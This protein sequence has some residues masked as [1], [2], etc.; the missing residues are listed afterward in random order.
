M[1]KISQGRIKTELAPC[2]NIFGLISN[3]ISSSSMYRSHIVVA[4]VMAPT[5]D[6]GPVSAKLSIY[7]NSQQVKMRTLLN[8]MLIFWLF[9]LNKIYFLFSCSG[10]RP[11]SLRL[12]IHRDKLDRNN[13]LFSTCCLV[14]PYNFH[15]KILFNSILFLLNMNFIT[16]KWVF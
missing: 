1:G 15:N 3:Q 7:F 2:N 5:R 9:C 6:I 12:T 11:Q 10:C 4:A 16:M 13:F 14:A 8:R